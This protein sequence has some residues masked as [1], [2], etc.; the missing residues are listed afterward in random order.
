[1]ASEKPAGVG[2]GL[3]WST[4]AFFGTEGLKV[5]NTSGNIWWQIQLLSLSLFAIP[6]IVEIDTQ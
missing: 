3:G 6:I 5:Q 4:P 2:E 1:M